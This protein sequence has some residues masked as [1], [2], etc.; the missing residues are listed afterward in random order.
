MGTIR[1]SS[2]NMSPPEGHALPR[3]PGREE[4][5]AVYGTPLPVAEPTGPGFAGTSPR[6]ESPETLVLFGVPFHNLT[7]DEALAGIVSRARSGPSAQ[8]LTS[9]LDFIFQAWK[10]PEMHRIHLEA[11]LVFADGWPP[12]TFSRFFGPSL[13]ERVAGSDLVP[14][15]ALAA[16]DHGLSIYALSGKPAA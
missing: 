13:R 5:S 4:R 12:V 11:A 15:L 1:I 16:R 2:S 6:E 9:N 14:H 3:E 10:D 7:F 8:I